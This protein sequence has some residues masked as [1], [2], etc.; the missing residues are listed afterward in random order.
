MC[1]EEIGNISL[2]VLAVLVC[3]AIGL[4]QKFALVGPFLLFRQDGNNVMVIP[5]QFHLELH[6]HLD[7]LLHFS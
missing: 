5:D 4:E 2:E 3:Q 6:V 1:V 7:L